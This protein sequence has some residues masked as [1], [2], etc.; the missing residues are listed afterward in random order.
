MTPALPLAAA[1]ARL[2]GRPGRPR[3]AGALAASSGAPS[4]PSSVVP[5]A[6]TR[7]PAVPGP[8]VV[9]AVVPAGAPRLFAVEAAG[10]YLGCSSWVIRDLIAAGELP[11]VTLPAPGGRAL[12]RLLVDRADLDALIARSK[13]RP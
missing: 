2:R 5:R 3:K 12:R 7:L 4:A 8:A 6:V 9:P 13:A 11:R 10:A 1:A